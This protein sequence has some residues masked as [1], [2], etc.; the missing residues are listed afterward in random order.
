M[1]DATLVEATIHQDERGRTHRIPLLK[2]FR[3]INSEPYLFLSV[4]P[5]Q[6]TLR[7]FHFQE[8]PFQETKLISCTSGSIFLALF[9]PSEG[10]SPDAALQTFHISA[11]TGSSVLV[12]PGIATAWLT[13]ESETSVLYQISGKFSPESARGYRF[14][15]PAINVAWP[16]EPRVIGEKDANWPLLSR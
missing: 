2:D 5:V 12:E 14:D 3:P 6:H 8:A 16:T 13:L 7:G 4:N 9:R 10:H 11:R 15:D 1:S